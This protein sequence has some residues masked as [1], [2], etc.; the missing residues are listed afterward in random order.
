M[1]VA[2]CGHFYCYE[3]VVVVGA[4]VS[5]KWDLSEFADEQMC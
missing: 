2:D 4:L 1:L 5:E 3:V